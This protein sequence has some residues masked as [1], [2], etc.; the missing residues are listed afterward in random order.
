MSSLSLKVMGPRGGSGKVCR[1]DGRDRKKRLWLTFFVA[2][3]NL[4]T[5]TLQ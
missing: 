5:S 3:F 4:V 1:V 2:V